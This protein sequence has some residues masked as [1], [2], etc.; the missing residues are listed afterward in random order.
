MTPDELRERISR[1]F[2]TGHGA[3]ADAA[4]ALPVNYDNLRKMLSP[5]SSR[6]VASWI[7]ARLDELDRLAQIEPPP[8]TLHENA[9]RDEPC[10]Q[11]LEPHLDNLLSR[12]S[13]VGWHPA[14]VVSAVLG[15]AV[16]ATADNAGPEAAL[17]LL[18]AAREIVLLRGGE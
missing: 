5:T 16:H 9:D 14:E 18:D 7:E 10:A 15:W 6:P 2:G 12:A 13:A 11:A 3:I 4:R 17:D 1:T 8:V